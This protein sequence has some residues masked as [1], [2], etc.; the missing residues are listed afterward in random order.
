LQPN[1]N[2][3]FAQSTLACSDSEERGGWAFS[4]ATVRARVLLR[5]AGMGPREFAELLF[6]RGAHVRLSPGL[7]QTVKTLITLS[8]N[9]KAGMS[10]HPGLLGRVA[11][12][13]AAKRGLAVKA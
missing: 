13:L 10:I 11:E 6:G 9:A 8:Q 3:F 1:D 4:G 5:V 7:R 12:F 2:P